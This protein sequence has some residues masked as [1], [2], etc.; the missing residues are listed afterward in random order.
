MVSYEISIGMLLMPIV[1]YTGSLNILDIGLKQSNMGLGFILPFFPLFMLFFISSLAETNRP[2]FDLPEAEA[3][4]VAGY[5][6][7]YSAMGFAMFF[8][9]EYGNIVFMS[10]LNV[11]LFFGGLP[12]GLTKIALMVLLFMFIWVRVAFPRYRYDQLMRLGWKSFLPLSL[13]FISFYSTIF[14]LVH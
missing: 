10:W 4:L 9:A 2:P 8:I 12:F 1:L 14:L 5:S 7:E 3:E 6:T 11:L 13:A